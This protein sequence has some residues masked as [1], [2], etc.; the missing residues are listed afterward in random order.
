MP[1]DAFINIRNRTVYIIEKKFQSVAGSV[2]EKLQTCLYKKTQY[3]KL[4]SQTEYDI[5][6]I[7]VLN[8]WF[9]QDKYCDVLSYIK[10]VGCS[11]FFN[12]LPLYF[13]GI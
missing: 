10:Y 5:K 3:E 8:D 7:C 11:C 2:D 13:L 1:D 4:V 12:E 6:Y 9:R